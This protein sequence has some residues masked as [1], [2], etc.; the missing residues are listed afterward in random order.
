MAITQQ[1]LPATSNRLNTSSTRPQSLEPYIISNHQRFRLLY[2]RSKLVSFILDRPSTLAHQCSN[3]AGMIMRPRQL[4]SNVDHKI[5]DIDSEMMASLS[6]SQA[7]HLRKYPLE[8][9]DK[10]RL[11]FTL[12]YHLSY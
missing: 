5:W 7:F 10:Y 12:V 3:N 8:T 9:R 4:R 6:L 11:P 2:H 1:S